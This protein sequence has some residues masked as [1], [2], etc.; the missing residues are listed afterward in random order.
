MEMHGANY[1]H[2]LIWYTVHVVPK[3]VDSTLYLP[4]Y[5][6]V[7]HQYMHCKAGGI[8]IGNETIISYDCICVHDIVVMDITYAFIFTGAIPINGVAYGPTDTVPIAY[9]SPACVGT[10]TSLTDCPMFSGIREGEPGLGGPGVPT[11]MTTLGETD[12]YQN[13]GSVQGR[14]VG[15]RCEGKC[16]FFDHTVE[17]DVDLSFTSTSDCIACI[18]HVCVYV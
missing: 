12:L 16:S 2:Y 11:V 4:A 1:R 3:I 13:S 9:S 5:S 6:S 7:L 8:G 17:A 15:V 10:E 18:I 14:L